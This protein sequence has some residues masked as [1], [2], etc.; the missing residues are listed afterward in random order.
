MKVYCPKGCHCI[1][2]LSEL[3]PV[4]DGTLEMKFY[5]SVC[6]CMY[7]VKIEKVKQ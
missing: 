1:D 7:E 6:G 4:L 5:C 2:G 3:V